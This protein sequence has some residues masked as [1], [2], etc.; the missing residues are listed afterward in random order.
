M[1]LLTFD[2]GIVR[3][4]TTELPGIL[5]DMNISGSFRS[6]DKVQ[7]Q[8]SGTVRIPLGWN[9]S[10]ILL[11]MDLTSDQYGKNC[12]EKLEIIDRIFKQTD[13]DGNP[14]IY[15][16]VNRHALA[17]GIHQVSFEKLKSSESDRNDTIK[18]TL[19]FKEYIPAIVQ[20]EETAARTSGDSDG[21]SLPSVT[22]SAPDI[23]AD[24]FAD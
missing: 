11:Q 18:V 23:D 4:G 24:I 13:K 5:T 10:N 14:Q 21:I 7:D 2:D 16:I 1:A 17:R 15:Q 22:V 12:Y 6:D 9:D 3:L 20:I 8:L 19:E